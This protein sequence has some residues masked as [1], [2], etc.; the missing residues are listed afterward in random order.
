ML[1]ILSKYVLPALC[2]LAL[3][4]Y[5]PQANASIQDFSCGG[6]PT[7][8]TGTVSSSGGNYST[9]GIGGLTTGPAWYLGGTSQVSYGFDLAFN[10]LAGTASLSDVSGGGSFSLNGTIVAGSV[11]HSGTYVAFEVNWTGEGQ[12]AASLVSFDTSNGNAAISVD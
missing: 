11:S 1:K 2:L 4:M 3:A 12:A 6:S 9:T 10:T 7:T 5:A 8:C